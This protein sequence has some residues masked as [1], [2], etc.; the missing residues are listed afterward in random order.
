MGSV[1]GFRSATGSGSGS[2]SGSGVESESFSK[3]RGRS[4]LSGRHSVLLLLCLLLTQTDE[5]SDN[6]P[7]TLQYIYCVYTITG[8]GHKDTHSF[9]ISIPSLRC[10]F[11]GE[12]LD[13]NR[14]WD[15]RANSCGISLP[16]QL[17]NCVIRALCPQSLRRIVPHRQNNFRACDPK[18]QR[19]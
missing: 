19:G 6:I 13:R 8:Q 11:L 3:G 14:N 5:L 2:R 1:A 12:C 9:H 16:A 4:Q 17:G 10:T 7:N 18:K 15:R